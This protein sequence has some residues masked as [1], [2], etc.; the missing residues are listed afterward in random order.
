MSWQPYIDDHLLT[1]LPHGGHIEHAAILSHS[2]D[3]WA[4]SPNFPEV[5]TEEAEAIMAGMDDQ[6]KLAQ[7]GLFIGGSKYIVVAGEEGAVIRGKQGQS[8][9]KGAPV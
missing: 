4:Q 1:E 2:G 5:S 6:I 3:V 9:A 7:Q 8:G